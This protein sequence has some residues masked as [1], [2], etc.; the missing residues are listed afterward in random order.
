MTGANY[1]QWTMK[2]AH[3]GTLLP[4][5]F[6]DGWVVIALGS[7]QWN[8]ILKACPNIG[9]LNHSTL[10]IFFFYKRG[11]T[12]LKNLKLLGLKQFY[13]MGLYFLGALVT[14]DVIFFHSILVSMHG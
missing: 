10:T 14:H 7:D 4:W 6:K 13:K 5:V 2:N 3:L 12:T 9:V 11:N 1:E 8:T